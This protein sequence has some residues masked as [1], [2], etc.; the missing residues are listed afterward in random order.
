MFLLFLQLYCIAVD[1][2]DQVSTTQFWGW[3]RVLGY[4]VRIHG[5]MDGEKKLLIFKTSPPLPLC[6]S[7]THIFSC[8]SSLAF[9]SKHYLEPGELQLQVALLWLQLISVF[10][11]FW[12][13]GEWIPSVHKATFDLLIQKWPEHKEKIMAQGCGV[14]SSHLAQ[15]Y[16]LVLSGDEHYQTPWA[17]QWRSGTFK[18]KEWQL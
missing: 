8:C 9:H 14:W 11:V 6:L 7:F 16:K 12:Q 3:G 5:Q 4:Y 1:S 13:N 2:T 18:G 15:G 10:L 17:F